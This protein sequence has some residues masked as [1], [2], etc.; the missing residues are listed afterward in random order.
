VALL[1]RPI[2]SRIP[3]RPR[4][5]S[6][7]PLML[8]IALFVMRRGIAFRSVGAD[9]APGRSRK[10]RAAIWHFSS[11]FLGLVS[12]QNRH[13]PWFAIFSPALLIIYASYSS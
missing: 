13:E 8:S 5:T 10:M 6:A 9:R 3:R 12:R 4:P 2:S 11:G 7:P 1:T